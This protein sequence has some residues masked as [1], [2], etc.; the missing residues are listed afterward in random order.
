MAAFCTDRLLCI[1]VYHD[2]TEI[3]FEGTIDVFYGDVSA[4]L[5]SILEIL[6]QKNAYITCQFKTYILLT[7]P[8]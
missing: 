2:R 3:D 4:M 7:V 5:D 8:I 1:T 6:I